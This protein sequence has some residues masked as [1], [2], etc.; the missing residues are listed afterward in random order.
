MDGIEVAAPE[1]R[2]RVGTAG[3][4]TTDVAEA[5]MQIDPTGT[6]VVEVTQ[7]P[8]GVPG[9][10][11]NDA[12]VQDADR[13][14]AQV[15]GPAEATQD[16]NPRRV[17]LSATDRLD[18]AY[19]SERQVGMPFTFNEREFLEDQVDSADRTRL[20]QQVFSTLKKENDEW[21]NRHGSLGISD[22]R[23]ERWAIKLEDEIA[24]E[25]EENHPDPETLMP[26][27]S[28]DKVVY[29]RG[30]RRIVARMQDPLD[31][32]KNTIRRLMRQITFVEDA[33][34]VVF[35]RSPVERNLPPRPWVLGGDAAFHRGSKRKLGTAFDR[36]N[37]SA[38]RRNCT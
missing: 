35:V 8:T 15:T 4:S 2:S 17:R 38:S 26:A 7:E 34:P 29:D 28:T 14:S 30:T 11:Q 16:V 32:F 13:S 20:L 27:G 23:L 19:R 3:L 37:V 25:A 9:A 36:C 10:S 12:Q 6:E 1:S 22:W 33:A 18:E 24:K 5:E 21:T 31:F